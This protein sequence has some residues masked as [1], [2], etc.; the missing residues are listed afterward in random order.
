MKGEGGVG[1]DGDGGF[2][3]MATNPVGSLGVSFGALGGQFV[4]EGCLAERL[5]AWVPLNLLVRSGQV[6]SEGA[7][8]CLTC[9]KPPGER[10]TIWGPGLW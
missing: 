4:L 9:L 1:G 6:R 10:S 7:T 3:L 5:P 8:S 2:P